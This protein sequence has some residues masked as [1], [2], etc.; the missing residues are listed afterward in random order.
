MIFW[1]ED[2]T[3]MSQ[4]A[5]YPWDTI[6]KEYRTATYSDAELARRHGCSR[7]AIQKRVAKEGW[8]RDISKAVGEIVRAKLIKEDAK[9]AGTVAGRNAGDETEQVEL[10][11]ETRTNVVKL[12]RKDVAKSQSLVQLFQGQ[13]YEA[14]T[15]RDEIEETIVDETK[16]EEGK[17]EQKRRNMMLKAVSLPAHAG[18]LRD[19]SV[20][21]KNLIYLERQAYN[22]DDTDGS[23]D[24]PDSI[25]ITVNRK[26]PDEEKES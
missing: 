24:A 17:A 21:Q 12:H 23:D 2:V 8:T 4:K 16:S 5:K 15:K 14:A 22:L 18:V 11:A 19:L 13:L 1:R 7:K 3:A 20:A 6:Y 9:V 25:V 26:R 10:A